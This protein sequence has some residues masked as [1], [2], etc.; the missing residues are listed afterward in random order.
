MQI[1]N[2]EVLGELGR[3]GMAV[4]YR[5]RDLRLDRQVAIKRLLTRVPLGAKAAERLRI[6]AQSVARLHHPGIVKI[7]EVVV[8]GGALVL[9][10]GLVVG[11]IVI[12]MLLPIFT[13]DPTGGH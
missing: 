11:A 7:H 12:S 4:V 13:L 6:E 9:I 8:D 1:G 2:Y 5:A 3:G 10:M